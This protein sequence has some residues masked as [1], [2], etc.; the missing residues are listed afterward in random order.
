M[1]FNVDQ[2]C[3]TYLYQQDVPVIVE[4]TSLALGMASVSEKY[5]H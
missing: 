2:H 1:T 4:I 5:L 3:N